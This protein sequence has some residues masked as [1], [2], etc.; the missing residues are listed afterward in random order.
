[1]ISKKE[2]E[3]ILSSR[4]IILIHRVTQLSSMRLNLNQSN[5]ILVGKIR[6]EK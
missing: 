1:M 6:T 5:N 2:L 3:N 4:I